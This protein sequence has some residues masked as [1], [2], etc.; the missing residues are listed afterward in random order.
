MAQE[1]RWAGVI[2]M[3][4]EDFDDLA[5]QLGHLRKRWDNR[6][7][8]TRSYVEQYLEGNLSLILELQILGGERPEQ[9]SVLA[10][11][12]E[13]SAG[14]TFQQDTTIRSKY[15]RM[16]N[17]SWLIDRNEQLVFVDNIH[18]VDGI[19]KSVASLVCIKRAKRIDDMWAGRA[20]FSQFDDCVRCVGAFRKREIDVPH[21]RPS[22]SAQDIA[23]ENIKSRMQVMQHIPNHNGPAFRWLDTFDDPH[24]MLAGLRISIFDNAIRVFPFVHGHLSIQVRDVLL[25]PLDF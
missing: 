14:V 7:Q 24:Q 3:P 10:R 2:N 9:Y 12:H 11:K 5:N 23:R 20:Y 4:L 6:F 25:G 8:F 17:S 1:Y 21:F 13:N 19:Q 16:S 22:I 18:L 15:S